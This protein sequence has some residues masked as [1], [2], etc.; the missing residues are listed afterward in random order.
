MALAR[1]GF[2]RTSASALG[3][4]PKQAHRFPPTARRRL[5]PVIAISRPALSMRI[6]M[7]T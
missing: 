5:T 4:L 2:S 6:A 1:P 7:T 3:A